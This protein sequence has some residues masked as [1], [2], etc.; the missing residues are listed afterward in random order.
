MEDMI[1]EN[2]TVMSKQ[3]GLNVCHKWERP[4]M[5]TDLYLNSLV[6]VTHSEIFTQKQLKV[7][8]S[9]WDTNEEYSILKSEQLYD[10]F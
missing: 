10:V 3:E 9:W 6:F 2:L 8:S 7:V 5:K 1:Q 4:T